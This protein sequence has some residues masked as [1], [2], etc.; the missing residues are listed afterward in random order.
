[1]AASSN[2]GLGHVA[3]RGALV[4]L[5]SQVV[6]TGLQ[7]GSVLVLARLLTP[8]DYG[9]MAMVMAVIGVGEMV[10]DLGLSPAAI[11]AETLSRR[12][13]DNLFWINTGAG[14]LMAVACV[15]VAPLLASFYGR[16]EVAAIALALAPGFLLSGLNTQYRA[17]L[18]RQ[19]RYSTLAMVDIAAAVLAL[20]LGIS[21]AL[22]GAGYWALVGQQL[23]SG[24]LGLVFTLAACRWLPRWY[25]RGEPMAALLRLGL[26]IFGTQVIYYL[27]VNI[28]SV[29]V[30]RRFGTVDAGYYNRGLQLVRLP[31]SQ[32]RTPIGQVALPVLSRSRRDPERF[33]SFLRQAQI[34]LA[35]PLLTLA[36]V[37]VAAGP[38]VVHILLGET[39]VPA[40][41]IIRW[42]A[43]G[44]A[45]ATSGGVAVWVFSSVGAG[46]YLLS[47]TL[48]TSAARIAMLAVGSQFSPT[49]VAAAYA[50]SHVVLLP[51]TFWQAE[52]A[53][54]FPVLPLLGEAAR[55]FAT[56]AVVTV[57]CWL[58]VRGLTA[59][60]WTTC[61]VA[62]A[63]QLGGM[64][65][66]AVIPRV[67]SDY[68]M[69]TG[70]VR[71]ATRRGDAGL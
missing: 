60:P 42:I 41:S 39:W 34:A 8:H 37:V 59:G 20:G 66:L 29:L 69:L 16:G 68:A 5:V 24:V 22:A 57:G 18:Q 61:L 25:A 40:T 15:G 51:V 13:R 45:V 36:G 19:L 56:V 48:W 52:R 46:G 49:A 21:M 6:R 47:F 44:E 2:G 12:Q 11:Q 71:L 38:D 55:V 35:Y 23:A 31:M 4:S 26:A 10:R 54:G 32:L 1:M 33:M 27:T 9:L 67:R 70:M 58:V 50:L 64:S 63:V 7:I 17:D 30:G 65:A 62:L 14:G 3:A 28:D 43:V 53:S